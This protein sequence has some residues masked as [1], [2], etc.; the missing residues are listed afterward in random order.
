MTFKTMLIALAL[1]VLPAV[2]YAACAGHSNLAQS[3]AP[4]SVWDAETATCTQQATG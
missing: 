4:G 2:S 1:T 3:C